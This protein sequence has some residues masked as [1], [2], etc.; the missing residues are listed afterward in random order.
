MVQTSRLIRQR[1]RA[2]VAPLALA[3]TLATAIPSALADDQQDPPTRVGRV[4]MIDGTVSFHPSPDDQWGPAVV[5][6]PVAASTAIWADDNSQAEIDVGSARVKLDQDTEVDIV[7]LDD[8]NVVLSVPQ[9]RVDI[10]L[11]GKQNDETYDVQTPRGDVDLQGD[12]SYRVFAGSDKDP[13]RVAAFIG[14]AQLVGGTSQI[15]VNVNQEM[16][17]TPGA[18]VS[19]GVASASQDAFDHSFFADVQKIYAHPVPAYVP[20][21]PGVASLSEYGAWRDDSS[22]GHVWIPTSVPTGWQPYHNGHWGYI[23][24][25]G[26]T[27]IDDAPWGFAPFHYGRWVQVGSAWGWVPVEPN[28]SVQ[29]GFHPVYSPA[30]VAFIGDPAAL[31]VGAAV[32]VGVAASVGWVPLAPNEPFVPWYHTSPGYVRNVN[33]VN[34]NRTVITNITNRTVINNITYNNVRAATVVPSAAFAGGRPIAAAGSAAAACS[35]RASDPCGRAGGGW[36]AHPAA[37]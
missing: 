4:A 27:W 15:T 24:P 32:G 19:Y 22:Y 9:G 5:N 10:S 17:A 13:T 29:V 11:H 33:I 30:M 26:Y 14:Q 8:Q 12:G 2:G 34:V 21:V 7:Q 25:W 31:T 3:A 36:P 1:L 16:T 35:V 28:V 20:A 18:T 6:Y 37:S 23:A